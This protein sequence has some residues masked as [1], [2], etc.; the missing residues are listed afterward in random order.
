MVTLHDPEGFPINLI[1]GQ[2]KKEP[3]PFPEVLTTNY[4]K[5]K[6]RIARFQRFNRAIPVHGYKRISC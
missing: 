2:T 1:F 3:G 4:E 6:P 5:D